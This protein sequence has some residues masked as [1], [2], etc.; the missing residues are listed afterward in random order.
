MYFFLTKYYLLYLEHTSKKNMEVTYKYT[1]LVVST[2]SFSFHNTGRYMFTNLFARSLS[3][4]Y[5]RRTGFFIFTFQWK[6]VFLNFCYSFLS[7]ILT[8][9]LLKVILIV[10][11]LLEYHFAIHTWSTKTFCMMRKHF[12]F[13]NV[14][15]IARCFWFM[16][17][18]QCWHL[19]WEM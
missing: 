17:L 4:Y 16:S 18:T 11:I 19:N 2:C 9:Y 8:K 10:N 14:R 1:I 5:I 6:N 3:F 13:L 15:S 7:N 12:F